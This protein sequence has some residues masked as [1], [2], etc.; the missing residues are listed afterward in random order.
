MIWRLGGSAWWMALVVAGLGLAMPARP[1][2]GGQSAS[3][4]AADAVVD[5]YAARDPASLHVPHRAVTRRDYVEMVRPLAA[6]F[7]RGPDHGSYGPRHALPALAVFALEGDVRL[8]EGIKKTLRH[9]GDWVRKEIEKT[10]G[11]FSMEGA[12][13]L[14]FYQ[15]ELRRRGLV[16]AEDE[17]WFKQMFLALRQYQY[18]WRPGDGLWRGSHHR[19]QCQGINHALAAA[20]YP[21]EPDAAK[22]NDY[23][24][25]VWGDWWN[26]RDVGINDTGYFYSSLCSILKAA[27]LLDRREVFTD[28]ESR[29]LFDR[30]L[31]ELTPDGVD[32]PYGASGGYNGSAGARIFVLELAA[33]H[34]RDGRYRWGAHRLMNHGQARGFSS[35][36]HHLNALNLEY[37]ALASLVCDDTVQPVQPDPRSMLLERKEIVRLSD[38]EARRMF[39]EAGGVDCNMWMTQKTMPHKLVLRSGWRPG[40]LFMMI[41]CYVRHDPLNPTAVLA[42][43]RHS[44]AMA[45]MTSEKFV[46]RENAVHLADLSGT[47]SYLGQKPFQ[48]QKKLP[49]GYVGM[50]CTVPELTETDRIVH[51]R[52]C[53]TNYMGYRATHQRDILMVKNRFVLLRDET[54]FDDAFRAAIGPAWNTQHVG[55]P[56]GAHWLNTWFSAHYFQ[57]AKL[58]DVPPWDLLIWYAPK[59]GATLVVESAP[60]DTPFASRVVPTRYTWQGEVAPGARVQF[61]TLLLPHAPLADATRLAESIRVLADEPGI[62]AV[63]IDEGPKPEIVVLNAPRRRL[64]FDDGSPNGWQT[65]AR[66]AY[67]ELGAG[68]PADEIR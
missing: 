21:D 47:A 1:A 9:Y 52:V 58:Y 38:A 23:A 29:K 16:W 48:G 33:R 60:V 20:F 41:E 7:E 13:L 34:T 67:L 42:L 24:A 5:R 61:I 62:A 65:S 43:E 54:E 15:R 11:V 37:I 6:G 10:G 25:K 19:S 51:A 57:A 40:D 53:V 56:R 12:T 55:Q 27:E 30:V 50:E 36:H 8:G 39:P 4:A 63:R 2:P 17:Q 46:S 59:P 66:A 64:R 44:A 45:E 22:W 35:T 68:R 32:V 3:P 49:L 31:F 18:A 14:A 28:A 26:F